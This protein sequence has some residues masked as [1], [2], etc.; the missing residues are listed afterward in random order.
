MA[1]FEPPIVETGRTPKHPELQPL[2]LKV[3]PDRAFSAVAA[4]AGRIKSWTVTKVDPV[5]RTLVAEARSGILGF[6]DDVVVRVEAEAGGSV[7]HMRSSSRRAVMDLRSVHAK[8]IRRFLER[9]Q[10]SALRSD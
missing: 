4:V 3:A 2:H 10:K 6:L 1:I 9:V 7:V 5:G 8:R